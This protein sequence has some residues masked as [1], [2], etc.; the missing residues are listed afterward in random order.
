MKAVWLI[1]VAA[2]LMNGQADDAKWRDLN[3]EGVRL[4]NAGNFV[5]AEVRFRAALVEA[6]KFGEG[7][8][9]LWAN[10]S[11]LAFTRQQQ[12]DAQGAEKLYRRVLE[13]REKYLGPNSSE[14][15]MTLNNIAASLRAAGRNAEADPVLRRALLIAEGNHDDKVTA[16]ILNTLGLVLLSEGERA[17]AEPVL[18]RAMALFEKIGGPDSLD[19]GKA[20]NNLATVYA[21]EGEFVK[22]EEWLRKAAPIYEKHL[23]QDHPDLALVWNNMFT[24]LAA[25]KRY[26]EAEPYLR[27]AIE[28][29]SRPGVSEA[30]A[31]KVRSNSASLELIHGNWQAAAKNLEEVIPVEERLFGSASPELAVALSN[32]SEAMK[33]LH[34][35]AE[36]K[37]AATRAN[38]IINSLR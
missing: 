38:A 34:H 9:R 7:D 3:S 4:S 32:Y 6:E 31:T 12:G 2:M 10:L 25:Q 29:A 17:R 22:A 19:A 36:A 8:Y 15:A 13:L 37:R 14:V 24:A 20:A 1:A 27:R 23:P 11:N 33:H 16:A 28:I 30:V 35:N 26:D 18:R 5:V 21:N